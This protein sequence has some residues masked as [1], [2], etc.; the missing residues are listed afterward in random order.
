MY[1]LWIAILF[2]LLCWEPLMTDDFSK[3]NVNLFESHLCYVCLSPKITSYNSWSFDSRICLFEYLVWYGKK[4]LS[5]GNQKW[6]L[7]LQQQRLKDIRLLQISIIGLSIQGP[8][9]YCWYIRSL[10]ASH[11]VYGSQLSFSA[12]AQIFQQQRQHILALS[13]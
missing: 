8:S 4:Y 9:C 10:I 2:V 5:P 13:L 11:L 7:I 12:V 1:L 3:A 6:L